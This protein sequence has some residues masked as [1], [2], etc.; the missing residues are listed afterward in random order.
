M[1]LLDNESTSEG[2]YGYEKEG[3]TS[4]VHAPSDAEE[5]EKLVSQVYQHASARRP[6]KIVCGYEGSSLAEKPNGVRKWVVKHSTGQKNGIYVI[7]ETS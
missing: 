5:V 3:S 4:A 6:N 2:Y 1:P 7:N